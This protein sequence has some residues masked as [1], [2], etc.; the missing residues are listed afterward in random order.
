[1]TGDGVLGY[2]DGAPFDRVVSTAA[3]RDVVP[4]AWVQQLRPDC[5]LVTPWG[6]DWWNGFLLTLAMTGEGRA[7]GRF[8]GNL[9][10]MRVRAQHSSLYGFEPDETEIGQATATTTECRGSDLAAM[11]DPDQALFA[12]GARVPDCYRYLEWDHFGPRHHLL[13]LD[14]GRTRSFA[15]LEW[16]VSSTAPFTVRQLGARRLWDEVEKAY[17]WWRDQGRPGMD[18]FGLEINAGHQWLWLDSPDHPV[19]DLTER[20]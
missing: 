15:R 13:D 16:D 17:V 12:I 7:T 2:P 6:T 18:R 3:I 11:L 19:R 1:M 14:D 9:S 5:R 8:S 10:F 4:P 20:P